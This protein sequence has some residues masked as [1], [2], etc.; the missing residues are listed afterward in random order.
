MMSEHKK[1]SGMKTY[2]ANAVRRCPK[3]TPSAASLEN[4]IE[5]EGK[6]YNGTDAIGK[7][8]RK[9]DSDGKLE[10]YRDGRLVFTVNDIMARSELSLS[11]SKKT[12]LGYRKYV[13]F[14]AYMSDAV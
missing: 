5:F 2:K 13:P 4:S 1:D 14:S 6:T 10:V 11:E 12:G 7:I 3:K 9:I 8:C